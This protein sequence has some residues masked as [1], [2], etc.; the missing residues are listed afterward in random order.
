MPVGP[1]DLNDVDKLNLINSLNLVISTIDQ[2]F[3]TNRVYLSRMNQFR[4]NE[5]PPMSPGFFEELKKR[6]LDA[7]WKSVSAVGQE[8][9]EGCITTIIFSK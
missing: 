8:L 6:Y 2:W 5:L 1:N 7:G 3:R 9:D 4:A